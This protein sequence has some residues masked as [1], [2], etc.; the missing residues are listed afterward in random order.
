V[1]PKSAERRNPAVRVAVESD[2][3]DYVRATPEL[4]A[5]PLRGVP[6]LDETAFFHAAS[7][8]LIAADLLLSACARDHWTW[9]LAARIW[10]RYE[11]VRTPPDVRMRTRPGA[12]VAESIARMRALSLERILVAHA[13]PITDRP[14]Q[15]LAEAWSFSSSSRR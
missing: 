3:P 15:R 5:L 12:A 9:R 6:F 13:D 10:G 4:A 14:G 7:G 2:D 11:Q 1:G 8:T